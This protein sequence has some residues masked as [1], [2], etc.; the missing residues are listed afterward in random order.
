[1]DNWVVKVDFSIISSV[2]WTVAQ[3]QLPVYSLLEGRQGF[4]SHRSDSN[5]GSRWGASGRIHYLIV[6]MDSCAH[7]YQRLLNCII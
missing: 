4:Q 5:S 1:M 7:I 3:V 6:V 2:L